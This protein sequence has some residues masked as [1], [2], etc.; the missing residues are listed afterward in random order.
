MSILAT[1][2]KMTPQQ[3]FAKNVEDL[4]ANFPTP[5]KTGNKT[6][7]DD[8]LSKVGIL[9]AVVKG[10]LLD[11]DAI[12]KIHQA[13]NEYENAK[14]NQFHEAAPPSEQFAG[15]QPVFKCDDLFLIEN[16]AKCMDLTKEDLEG[17]LKHP[18]ALDEHLGGAY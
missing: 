9:G 17:V 13:Y 16:I 7:D 2:T 1:P 5:P 3:K 10:A 8:V 11:T 12:T 4:V 15:V 14:R 6:V 18:I